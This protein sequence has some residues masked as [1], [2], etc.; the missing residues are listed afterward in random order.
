MQHRVAHALRA[1]CSLGA[2]RQPPAASIVFEHRRY[3]QIPGLP[4]GLGNG[5]LFSDSATAASRAAGFDAGIVMG[6][7]LT[8]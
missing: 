5:E 3:G 4:I 2:A 8:V 6:L 1:R 7:S